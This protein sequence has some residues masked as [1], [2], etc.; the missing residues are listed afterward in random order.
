MLALLQ[1]K[2]NEEIRGRWGNGWE[3]KILMVRQKELSN[4]DLQKTAR[5]GHNDPEKKTNMRAIEVREFRSTCF[6]WKSLAIKS[7]SSCTI[8]LEGRT[9]CIALYNRKCNMNVN[10]SLLILLFYIVLC[11]NS[12]K[13]RHVIVIN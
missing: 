2:N 1:R 10:C 8:C 12:N 6:G 4:G 11:N 7:V 5:E 13:K 9:S 3:K